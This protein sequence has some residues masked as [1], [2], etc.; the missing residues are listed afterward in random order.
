MKSRSIYLLIAI[1]C[2]LSVFA[3][4]M[5]LTQHLRSAEIVSAI[6]NLSSMYGTIFVTAAIGILSG[7][8]YCSR[9]G[10]ASD[11]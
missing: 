3:H 6:G 2:A 10:N 4:I 1:A 8:A 7:V 5:T 9:H 11:L